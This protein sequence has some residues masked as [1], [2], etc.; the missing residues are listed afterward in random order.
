MVSDELLVEVSKDTMKDLERA[1]TKRNI[2]AKRIKD[3][4]GSFRMKEE[5]LRNSFRRVREHIHPNDKLF[6][7]FL[8][9]V[10]TNLEEVVRLIIKEAR[11]SQK[12]ASKEILDNIIKNIENIQK[13]AG[14][15]AVSDFKITM[16][17]KVNFKQ[18]PIAPE[19]RLIGKI[20]EEKERIDSKADT[21]K[22]GYV[23][24]EKGGN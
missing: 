15:R 3:F 8:T 12:E 13:D 14:D 18:A 23:D 16:R 5:V 21:S 19:E 10:M 24:G 17:D 4:S 2:A 20:K 7:Y 1:V 6:E 9:G 22:T 11:T